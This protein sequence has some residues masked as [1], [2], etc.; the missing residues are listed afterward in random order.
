MVALAAT[1]PAGGYGCSV[2]SDRIGCARL[3]HG[4]APSRWAGFLH[5]GPGQR[6]RDPR[7]AGISRWGEF[8]N[9]LQCP[10]KLKRERRSWMLDPIEVERIQPPENHFKS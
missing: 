4:A 7:M 5:V 3:R 10:E 1:D 6:E 8:P 2:G 9:D